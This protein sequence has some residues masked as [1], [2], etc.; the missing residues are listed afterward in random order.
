M[1][2]MHRFKNV[3]IFIQTIFFGFFS[4]TKTYFKSS[5]ESCPIKKAVLKLLLESLFNKVVGLQDC[6]KTY[7]Y[8]WLGSKNASGLLDAPCKM[9]P[10]NSFI[11]Q[12]LF[13]CC[14]QKWKRYTENYLI[15]NF[16]RFTF[17]YKHHL[18][19]TTS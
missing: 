14:F 17:I 11:L 18:H 1:I 7:L 5:H 15:A 4:N 16:T 10:L 13:V 3:V 8:I 19:I 2:E 12:Y 6:C 9:A